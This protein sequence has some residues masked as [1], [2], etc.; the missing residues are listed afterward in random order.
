MMV[1]LYQYL[2]NEDVDVAHENNETV[3]ARVNDDSGLP[4]WFATKCQGQLISGHFIQV[5]KT[6]SE[7]SFCYLCLTSYLYILY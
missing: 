3:V 4:T 1:L 7:F 2:L 6:V 5:S